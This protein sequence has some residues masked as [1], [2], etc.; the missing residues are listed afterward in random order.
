VAT[1]RLHAQAWHARVVI[2]VLAAWAL[3]AAVLVPAAGVGPAGEGASGSPPSTTGQAEGGETYQVTLIT[4]DVVSWRALG[5]GRGVATVAADRDRAFQTIESG[6]DYYVIPNEVA[7]LVGTTLDRELFNIPALVEQGFHDAATDGI[8]V[9][10]TGAGSSG[11]RAPGSAPVWAEAVTVDRELDS[12]DG[13]AGTVEHADTNLLG[14]E[15][16]AVAHEVAAGGMGVAAARDL[17]TIWLDRKVEVRLEESVP[18]TGAPEAWASGYD[19][20]GTTIAVL[21][22]GIDETHPD[23]GDKVVAS[24][25]FSD[26]D[27]A[28]DHHGHGT[29][30]AATAAGTGEAS[31]GL[32]KG[33]A[34]GADLMNVKVLDD[35]GFGQIS[36]IVAGMEWAAE[37]GADV[38]SMSLGGGPTDGTDPMSQAVNTIT[39]E[40][41]VLFVIAAGNSGPWEQS[42]E[43]P[44][45][46][47]AALTVG[48]VDKQGALASFS[49]RGPRV[50]DFAIKP[51][52]TAPGVSIVAARAAGTTMGTPVDDLYTSANGTSMA[53][54]HVAGAAAIMLQQHP[55]WDPATVKG[56][57]VGTAGPAEGL[58][59]YEQGGGELDVAAAHATDVVATPGTLDLG[60]Y[61]YPNDGPDPVT[62]TLTYTNHGDAEVTL[63]VAV[64][65]SDEDG[66]P[67]ADGVVTVEPTTLTLAPGASG[68]VAVTV[69]VGAA[70]ESLH[71][72]TVVASVGG[73]PVTSTPTGFYKEGE[74]YQL[75]VE[76]VSADGRPAR[77]SVDVVDVADTTAY[78]ES[79]S[80]VGGTATFR[81]PPGTYSVLGVINTFSADDLTYLEQTLMGDPEIEITGDTTLT[82]DAREATEI[83]VDTGED[84][85]VVGH[86]LGYHRAGSELGSYTH[87]WVGGTWPFSAQPT[88]GVSTGFFEF[89]TKYEM[90]AAVESRFYDLVFPEPDVVPADLDYVVDPATLVTLGTDYHSDVAD[91]EYGWTRASWRPYEAFAVTILRYLTAPTSQTELV[92]ADDT[93]Y[94]QTVYALT[95]FTGALNE[96]V[97]TYEAGE[98]REVSWFAS[99]STPTLFEPTASSAGTLPVRDGDVLRLRVT[100]WGDAY[101]HEQ[102]HT[103]HLD[104]SV[105]TAAFRL[106]QDGELV[107]EAPRA[108]ADFPVAAGDSRLRLELDVAREADW[109]QTSVRTSTAWELDSSTTAGATPLPLLQLEYDLGLQL[110]NSRPHPASTTG[111]ATVGIQVRHPRG[112]AGAEIEGAR[113][114]ISYDDGGTWRERPVRETSEGWFEVVLDRRQGGTHASLRVHARDADG[115]AVEQDVIRAFALGPR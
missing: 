14:D 7:P 68:E 45:V 109:W 67:A 17:W 39:E 29:H 1:T 65:V 107:T 22:T 34:P 52:L 115:N 103:G 51:D 99:P 85:E 59:V 36:G 41:G 100:E 40:H 11:E 83:T 26:A 19:G 49:G 86:T 110:D 91:H 53:T 18:Q 78:L 76:G 42:V 35:Y 16:A 96:A 23:I 54:P 104:S 75:T 95:P 89:Y 105:D 31:D 13:F 32:R 21:D 77:G 47:D 87:S 97:T 66:N 106:Y 64:Q 58:T 4:G 27:S 70:A 28:V 73:E 30:V 92:T 55:D 88:E 5:E 69:D 90:E 98:Q 71:G 56:A 3:V 12:V 112:V 114:W 108:Y 48:A 6:E 113:V 60:Y 33:V 20:T 44:G 101:A 80:F 37:Q 43:A 8:P 63:E 102:Q 15:L 81:L 79:A 24:A 9:V 25:N 94:M 93:R 50:G 10:V 82:W 74:M 84:A 72:G 61:P 38:I 57:L 2:A 46:A 111:P 62:E